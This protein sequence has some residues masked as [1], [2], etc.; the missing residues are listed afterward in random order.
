MPVAGGELQA[1]TELEEFA[2]YPEW[3]RDTGEIVFSTETYQFVVDPH[4]TDSG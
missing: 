4:N 3:N 1:L 2:F